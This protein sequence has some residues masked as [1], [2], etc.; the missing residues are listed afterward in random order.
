MKFL[1]FLPLILLMLLILPALFSCSDMT[2][3]LADTIGTKTHTVDSEASRKCEADAAHGVPRAFFISRY[4]TTY[5]LWWTVKEFALENGYAFKNPGT[6]GS[7]TSSAAPSLRKYMPVTQVSF[8]DCAAWCNAYSRMRGYG[9]VYFSDAECTAE[10]TDASSDDAPH[11]DLSQNGFRIPSEG[12]WLYAFRGGNPKDA[13]W[14]FRYSG[15]DDA[16]EVAVFSTGA[17][18]PAGTKQANAAGLFDMSGNV[19]E[20]VTDAGG[21][22]SGAKGGSFGSDEKALAWNY[23]KFGLAQ[24]SAWSFIGFRTVRNAE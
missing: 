11:A 20:L 15:S 18:A 14:N 23:M 16:Q 17:A 3:D 6:E 13:S 21:T 22:F 7:G 2:G 8:R 19:W 1:R 24:D 4:E 10:Y 5:E 12:E 9:P